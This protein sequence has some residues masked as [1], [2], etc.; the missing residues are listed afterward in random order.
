MVGFDEAAAIWRIGQDI[1][2]K[3]RVR[4]YRVD[5][6]KEEE[7]KS[8]VL[9]VIDVRQ[10]KNLLVEVTV[11]LIDVVR[12]HHCHSL[13]P[14]LADCDSF[15]F[16]GNI[17]GRRNATPV[18]R[19]QLLSAPSHSIVDCGAT[20]NSMPDGYVLDIWM[21][22]SYFFDCMLQSMRKSLLIGF[23]ICPASVELVS[24]IIVL[25]RLVKA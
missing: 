11:H 7:S 1:E 19:L 2:S 18:S 15:V 12:I 24:A 6:T 16:F 13:I 14:L 21:V 9:V 10:V 8:C 23:K 4:L 22:V 20:N 3:L 17:P 5:A 25:L